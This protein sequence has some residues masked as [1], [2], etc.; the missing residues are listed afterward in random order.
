MN[1]SIYTFY[2]KEHQNIEV[3]TYV[4][5]GETYEEAERNTTIITIDEPKIKLS[6]DTWIFI[7]IV[8]FGAIIISLA[9][10]ILKKE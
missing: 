6:E 5:G 2:I 8:L 4:G 1:N 9:Y 10:W 3:P 7:Y